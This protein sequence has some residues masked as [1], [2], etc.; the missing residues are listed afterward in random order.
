MK[1]LACEMCGSTDLIKDGGVFVCQACGCKYSV[2]EARQ[3]MVGGTMDIQGTVQVDNSA[4]V[5]K[6]LVN[7]R[8]AKE[9]ED[10]EETEKYYNMVEQNDPD[11]I[12][13]IFYSAYGKAKQT[14]NDADIYKRQAAFKV[15][16][17][18]ISVIDDHY[19]VE[20]AEENRMAIENMA[21]DLSSMFLSTFVFT[22]WRNGYGFVTR[23]DKDETYELFVKLERQFRES[24][25]NIAKV[26]E[27]VYLYESLKL[28]YAEILSLKNVWNEKFKNCVKG[29]QKEAD[30]RISAL[31]NMYWSE[32]ADEKK[33]LD[34][35]K[36]SLQSQIADTKAQIDSL[37]E[38]VA[39]KNIED[40]ISVKK[41]AHHRLSVFKIKEQV[42]LQS[43]IDALN[44]RLIDAKMAKD[45]VVAPYNEKIAT[46]QKR[47]SEI[48]A[49]FTKNL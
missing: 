8:R 1:Q 30:E 44:N 5:A 18:C 13:A 11:N 3:M 35:K 15:L 2:E 24:I 4:F 9:K 23:S 19:Q 29:W 34:D 46:M 47:I 33:A 7:A 16:E 40:Q 14:L 37:T 42:A 43:E 48:D 27:H 6:Y 12:E 25:L 49:E 32:H 39:V 26:D 41:E 20:R 38:T 45:L 36:A 31:C 28:T 10:W 17:N 21:R 22:E